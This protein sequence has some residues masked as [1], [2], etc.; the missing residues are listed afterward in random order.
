MAK[1]IPR[2]EVIEA[3][4]EAASAPSFRIAA[5]RCALSPAAFTRR[6]QAF[7]AYAGRE[8]FERHARGVRLTDA[9]RDCL[10][11]VERPYRALQQAA[12]EFGAR[13]T[14]QR[15][16]LS[17]SH[18][19]TVGW[20]IPRLDRFKARHPNV[21][22]QIK[23]LRNAEAVRS[24]EADLGV[25]A[26]DVDAGGL[27]VEP[28]LDIHIAPVAAPQVAAAVRAG[29]GGLEGFRLLGLHFPPDVWGWWGAEA[30]LDGPPLRQA[31]TFDIIH[32]MYEAAA[33]GH[34]VAP[35]M[36]CTVE[37]HL[38]S[39]RLVTL[40]L[41][42]V[43]WPGGY[44]L[45]ARSSRLRNPAVMALWSW[46]IEEG[47]ATGPDALDAPLQLAAYGALGARTNAI[48]SAMR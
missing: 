25:C 9:G 37:P 12:Q 11:A 20:L 14:D 46:L 8:L 6:I 32:A 18:S 15:V 38:I 36:N 42:T 39:G 30:G 17:L 26:T 24:G 13:P 16:T 45:A 19:L 21:E 10:A 22:V 2:L 1:R 31:Q 28:M 27:H 43:R 4:I 40:G 7:T 29:R 44:R 41:P 5:E 34:G 23:T 47:R 48:R 33:S 35:G 3:F